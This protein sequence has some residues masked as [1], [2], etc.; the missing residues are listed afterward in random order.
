MQGFA[1]VPGSRI[2]KSS[3][4]SKCGEWSEDHVLLPDRAPRAQLAGFGRLLMS[5]FPY[6]DLTATRRQFSLQFTVNEV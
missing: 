4:R 2:L 5:L 3:R 6:R 1:C